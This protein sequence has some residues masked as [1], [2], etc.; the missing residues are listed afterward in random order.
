M[1]IGGNGDSIFKRLMRAIGADELAG[2]QAWRATTGRVARVA[3]I[4]AAIEAWTLQLTIAEVLAAL[5]AA[6]VPAGASTAWPTSR[7]TRNTRRAT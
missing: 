1:L 6:A 2:T 3:E 4:D 7:P 5:D